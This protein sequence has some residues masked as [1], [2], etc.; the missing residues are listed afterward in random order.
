MSPQPESSGANRK[1]PKANSL[2]PDSPKGP[3]GGA[4]QRCG[5]ISAFWFLS[6]FSSLGSP[7]PPHF[8][9]ITQAP[10]FVPTCPRPHETRTP[11]SN[12]GRSSTPSALPTTLLSS[13]P[14]FPFLPW[15]PSHPR[16][17]RIST[18]QI[19]HGPPTTHRIFTPPSPSRHDLPAKRTPS[20]WPQIHL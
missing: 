10:V 14:S 9:K 11:R 1:W 15:I 12:L 16:S 7:I 18:A 5:P 13:I 19:P 8:W 2:P 3:R 17:R 20:T 6:C 4:G